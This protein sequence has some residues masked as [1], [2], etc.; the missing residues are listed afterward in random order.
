[1]Y[2]VVSIALRIETIC[3]TFPFNC[4]FFSFGFAHLYFYKLA[5]LKPTI[6]NV[7]YSALDLPFAATD[8]GC[9]ACC[10]FS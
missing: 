7:K 9:D 5:N 1:M 6:V 8:C 2:L 4:H 10:I 3:P